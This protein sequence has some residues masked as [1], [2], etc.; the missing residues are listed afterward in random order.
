MI[1]YFQLGIQSRLPWLNETNLERHQNN[2]RIKS[3]ELIEDNQA[4]MIKAAELGAEQGREDVSC[5]KMSP[6]HCLSV[7]SCMEMFTLG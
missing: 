7:F 4:K 2:F 1:F 6:R 3:P 5:L